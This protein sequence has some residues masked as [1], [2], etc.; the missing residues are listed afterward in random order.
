MSNALMSKK[1]AAKICAALF[2]LFLIAIAVT[3][4]WWPGIM[5]AVGLPLALRQ[6]LMGRR[7]DMMVSLL[8]FVGTYITVEYEISWQV[9]LPILFSLGAIYVFFR[10]MTEEE[11]EPEQ[12]EDQNHEFEEKR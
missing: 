9:F 8:V 6:Y 1:R 7:Y 10:E 3:Q 2:F 4:N 11:T 5:L 12:E